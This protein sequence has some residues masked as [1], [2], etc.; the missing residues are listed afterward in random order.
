MTDNTATM[1]QQLPLCLKVP[2]TA[3]LLVLVE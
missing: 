1:H 3:E 2:R